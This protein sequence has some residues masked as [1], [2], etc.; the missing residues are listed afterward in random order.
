MRGILAIETATDACSVALCRGGEVLERHEVTPRQHSQRLFSMLAELLPDGRLAEHGIEAIAY[1]SGPGSF[2]GLRVAASAVQGLAYAAC[3]PAV[4]VSTLA[5]QVATALREGLVTDGQRVAS[6]IDARINEVYCA[7]F[8]VESGQLVQCGPAQA[9]PPS[10]LVL[11]D[12]MPPVVA[13]GSGA[14][15]L[16]KAPAAFRAKLE[17]IDTTLLPRARDLL[18]LAE[19]ALAAGQVQDAMQVR[20]VYVRD[21]INWKKIPQQGKQR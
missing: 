2:T 5:C 7:L 15:Y 20:P 18:P 14:A 4:P 3:L 16:D 1:G 12:A 13:V 11:P 17:H 21:E 9:C 8:Q 10:A 19:R 6:L